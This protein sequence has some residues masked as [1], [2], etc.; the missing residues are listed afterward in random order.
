MVG[1]YFSMK[2]PVTNWTVR[3]DLPT[4][5]DPKTTTLNSLIFLIKKNSNNVEQRVKSQR[6]GG[7]N[8]LTRTDPEEMLMNNKHR[9]T[10]RH[11]G[12]WPNR[13]LTEAFRNGKQTLLLVW[14]LAISQRASQR[15]FVMFSAVLTKVHE[16]LGKLWWLF[17][18]SL[19]L[20][21][22]TG[23]RKKT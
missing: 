3:A 12:L 18:N 14:Y 17:F 6:L 10:S 2:H 11:T 1:S 16:K 4:P 15:E 23:V 8:R 9:H 19:Q 20:Q 21:A 22:N 13:N 7:L 5:P